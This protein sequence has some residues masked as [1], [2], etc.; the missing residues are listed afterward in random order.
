MIKMSLA[1]KKLH[2]NE[3]IHFNLKPKNFLMMNEFQPVIGDFGFAKTKKQAEE[4]QIF[5]GSQRYQGY[6]AKK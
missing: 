4:I 5:E 2:D 1:V 6:K 3:I